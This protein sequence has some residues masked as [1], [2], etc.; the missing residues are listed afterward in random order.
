MATDLYDQA[1]KLQKMFPEWKFSSIVQKLNKSQFS[2]NSFQNLVQSK[3]KQKRK[4]VDN[5]QDMRKKLRTEQDK[6]N[7]GL[8]VNTVDLTST[9]DK[10][11]VL[12]SSED[13]NDSEPTIILDDPININLIKENLLSIFPECAPLYIEFL[14]TL[15]KDSIP[16]ENLLVD[17]IVSR[18]INENYPKSNNH[19]TSSVPDIIRSV[20]ES[21]DVLPQTV[22]N[23]AQF[24]DNDKKFLV[25]DLLTVQNS[26]IIQY[27]NNNLLNERIQGVIEDSVDRTLTD[28]NFENLSDKPINLSIKN[29]NI[30]D[31]LKNLSDENEFNDLLKD[32]VELERINDFM[33]LVSELENLSNL[34]Q[35]DTLNQ[36]IPLVET[37][38]TVEDIK[39]I[40]DHKPTTEKSNIEDIKPL[41][42]LEKTSEME[43]DINADN[44]I[45]KLLP[46]FP[47][48]CPDYLRTLC[49]GRQNNPTELEEI[50]MYLIGNDF[51]KRAIVPREN[52]AEQEV[53]D[54]TEQYKIMLELLPEADPDYL[55]VHCSNLYDKPDLLKQFIDEA[56]EHKNYPTIKDYKRKQQLSAQMKQYTTEF[57]VNKFL[58]LIPNPEEYFNDPKRVCTYNS[59]TRLDYQ[60]SIAIE[61]HMKDTFKNLFPTKRIVDINNIIKKKQK[62]VVLI[63]KELK[64]GKTEDMKRPRKLAPLPQLYGEIDVPYLQEIAYVTHYDIIHHVSKQREEE[65]TKAFETAKAN[66]LLL[67]CECCFDD[68]VM[69]KDTFTCLYGHKFCK[70]CI[71]RSVEISF[72]E[73]KLQ[74]TCLTNCKAEF[75]LATLQTILKPNMFSKIALRKQIDEVKSAGIEDLESCPFCDFATIPTPGDKIFKCLNDECLKESC[76]QCKELSHIPYRCDEI[77]KNDE[78]KAR[79]Y[80]E[81][82]MTEALLRKC[83]KCGMKF[84]KEDG[85]NKMTCRCGAL[86]CYVCGK[87][88]DGYNHFNG[89]GGTNYELCPLYSDTEKLHLDAVRKTGEEAKE[90]IKQKNPSVQLKHDPLTGLPKPKQKD[91]VYKPG[92]QYDPFHGHRDVVQQGQRP[93]Q[94]GPRFVVNF[95]HNRANVIVH[96]NL[97]RHHRDHVNV[98]VRDNRHV[99]VVVRENNPNQRRHHHHHHHHQ[100]DNRMNQQVFDRLRIVE[101]WMHDMAPRGNVNRPH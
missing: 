24:T 2:P 19:N 53:V 21:S 46:I 93:V 49:K 51:P 34:V 94:Q 28:S 23:S 101:N 7:M 68:E 67:T 12:S 85:C 43:K 37:K 40:I 74:F 25:H 63:Y 92:P 82:K 84:I 13:S 64:Y 100:I 18:L 75:S 78:V 90:E 98:V 61:S 83:W 88:V 14:I 22:D 11:I 27:K 36:R 17:H 79:T 97:N 1:L 89:Q 9:N 30:L 73:N 29:E 20:Q 55:R 8:C 4:H 32:D 65:K 50:I 59:S 33:Q 10:V 91:T 42:K 44:L 80:I 96:N 99:G 15:A 54:E 31:E 26:P 57:D 3:M 66:G 76:R 16:N 69:E 71:I 86:M 48:A 81:D 77:E 72:G 5:S 52:L 38:S 70:T 56:M 87:P 6:L 45:L 62:R 39:P 41:I 47:D 95:E 35:E 58:E 60:K